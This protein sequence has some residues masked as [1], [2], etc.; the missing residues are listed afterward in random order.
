MTL[1][2]WSSRRYLSSDVSATVPMRV[3]MDAAHDPSPSEPSKAESKGSPS[4]LR[5]LGFFTGELQRKALKGLASHLHLYYPASQHDLPP[6]Q[7]SCS[8]TEVSLPTLQ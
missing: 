1:S 5:R 8:D 6:S 2:L 4:S 3:L 7:L